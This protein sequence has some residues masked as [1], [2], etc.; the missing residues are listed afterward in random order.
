MSAHHIRYVY[1]MPWPELLVCVALKGMLIR[2]AAAAALV[3]EVPGASIPGPDLNLIQP[4]DPKTVRF[5]IFG[6]RFTLP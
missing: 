5:C 3:V 2:A 1:A 4:P 6:L